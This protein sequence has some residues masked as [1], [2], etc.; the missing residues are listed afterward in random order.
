M[1]RSKIESKHSEDNVP[2]SYKKVESKMQ[3]EEV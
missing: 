3:V 2:G 1:S